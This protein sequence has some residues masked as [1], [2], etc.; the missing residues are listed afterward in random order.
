MSD[1]TGPDPTAETTERRLRAAL[2]DRA[3]R[4]QPSADGLTR[5]E[6]KIMKETRA[7]DTQK[8]IYSGLAAA[9]VIVLVIVGF[10]VIGG[11]DD[12]TDVTADTTS[13][14]DTTTTTSTSSST[15][16]STTTMPFAPDVD[17]F[18]VAYPSPM[19]SQRFQ[20]P[21]SAAQAYATEVLGFTE[22]VVGQYQAGDNR[23]G[24]IPITDREGN[25]TTTVL[26]RQ[27][28]DNT[29]FV[30]GSIADDI[31]VDEPAAG[32]PV[33]SPFDT[34]GSALAFEGTV[35]VLVRA[36]DDPAVLGEGVVTGSGVPP[37]GPF[38]GSIEFSPPAEETPGVLVYRTMS[39]E[40]GHVMQAT[41][42]PVRLQPE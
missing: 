28:E 33:A 23:S 13:T 8:W 36:Q 14:T 40:D 27:M 4:I 21:D 32:E 11:D 20:S 16:T 1:P 17:P 37:A 30:L 22:L 10:V 15:S 35:Q 19:T 18:E 41:S 3:N 7:R 5:I 2:S 29:W 26:V 34:T 9:A 12:E 6:E 38:A 25:P 39:A 42:M 24:E 31:T